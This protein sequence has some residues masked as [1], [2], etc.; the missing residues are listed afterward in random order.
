MVW[1]TSSHSFSGYT[2][3]D[4]TGPNISCKQFDTEHDTPPGCYETA[5]GTWLCTYGC[6]FMCAS[7]GVYRVLQ[8]IGRTSCMILCLGSLVSTMVGSTKYPTLQA[9]GI[10]SG[11]CTVRI[12][13]IRMVPH[14]E[15]TCTYVY[16]YSMYKYN[17]D[18]RI[19]YCILQFFIREYC[20]TYT[21]IHKQTQTNKD[22]QKNIS[23]HI[24]RTKT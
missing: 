17:R 9:I 15:H 6:V 18:K 3:T 20:K 7:M 19:E 10:R 23:T 5:I 1:R 22:K 4:K 14:T 12:Y 11:V 2:Y 24:H 13:E 16:T 21:N 8:S